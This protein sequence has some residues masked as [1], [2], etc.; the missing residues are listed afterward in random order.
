MADSFGIPAQFLGVSQIWETQLDNYSSATD[1]VYWLFKPVNAENWSAIIPATAIAA[2]KWQTTA[3]FEDETT[4][5]WAW[6][7]RLERDNTV[8]GS[9]T[10]ELLVILTDKKAQLKAVNGAIDTLLSGGAVQSYSIRGRSLNRYSLTELM[11]L[12]DSLR[13]EIARKN[14][15]GKML[16]V[17]FRRN[18]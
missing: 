6:E 7:L 3:N 13:T 11:S 15:R 8:L 5:Q 10:F 17:A 9:G 1:G 4:T 16:K 12:R 2:P 18:W 14:G